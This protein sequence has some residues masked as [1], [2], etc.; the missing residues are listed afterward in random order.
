MQDLPAT[1]YPVTPDG[2]YFV[3]KGRLW[4]CSNPMI[5]VE[6]RQRLVTALMNARRAKGLA[7]RTG[8]DVLREASRKAM[9]AAKH[10][11]GSADPSGG[12]TEIRT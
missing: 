4:R 8:D 2:R 6:R 9:D 7:M 11:L 10:E 5:P 3:V 12:R 1:R